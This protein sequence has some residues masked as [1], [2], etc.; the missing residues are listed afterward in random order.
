MN[1]V[2]AFS[3]LVKE[4]SYKGKPKA[5]LFN[6]TFFLG[7]GFSKSWDEAFP[8]G[9][10]LFELQPK[11]WEKCEVLEEF[12]ALNNYQTV[13]LTISSGLFKDIVYQLGMLKK[14][15]SIRP[16][17][18]DEQNIAI[19]ETELRNLIYEKFKA[20]APLYYFDPHTEKLKLESPFTDEQKNI[21]DFF[22]RIFEESDGSGGVSEGLR[23][24]FI[25][26]NYDFTIDAI[27]DGCTAP[28]DTFNL[29]TYRGITSKS[30]SGSDNPTIV[31]NHWLVRNLLKINGG[32]EIFK[33]GDGYEV[34]YRKK[35]NSEIKANPPQIMLPSREQDYLQ[36]Y[37]QAIFPKAIRLLHETSALVIVG[38]S[39]PE[40]DALIRLIL[41]QFAEDR[42]DGAEKLVF[43]VDL[44]DD[45]T[46]INRINEVFPHVNTGDGLKVIP[47]S[48]K[49]ATWAKMVAEKMI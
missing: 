12:L 36:S 15:P 31:H 44:L 48:G 49:F 30:I 26:T 46:Q 40:E 16:R 1:S 10:Q 17:Y 3:T 39:L 27:L 45:S 4:K 33:C 28:D 29:Y 20:T 37:F 21:F 41:K 5:P 42:T 2:E 23:T 18:I 8:A 6:I 14:Y 13:N 32:F 38:Y 22:S 7:A 24:H 11:E 19:V 25:T 9:D 47:F 43:Y 34:D 35:P